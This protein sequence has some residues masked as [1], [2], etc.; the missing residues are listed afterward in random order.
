MKFC[1]SLDDSTG[2]RDF[3]ER[4]KED[5]EWLK[6]ALASVEH[7][8]KKVQKLVEELK[9]ASVASD[10]EKIL[11]CLRELNEEIIEV[12]QAQTVGNLGGIEALLALSRHS[13]KQV[14]LE[15]LIAVQATLKN[16]DP[17]KEQAKRLGALPFLLQILVNGK[18][19]LAVRFRALSATSALIDHVPDLQDAFV[20][21][22]GLDVASDLLGDAADDKTVSRTAFLLK[23]LLQTRPDLKAAFVK[24][25]GLV[26]DLQRQAANS[27]SVDVKE[28]S[29]E[30]L[31]LLK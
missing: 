30:F 19:D 7:P 10:E 13:S 23:W 18:E 26:S 2:L 17:L 3:G 11:Y 31:E 22:G 8:A 21:G 25:P 15:A 28:L 1:L 12:D 9:E 20:G 5:W 29:T 16:N 24:T 27:K 4:S 6:A 14:Q